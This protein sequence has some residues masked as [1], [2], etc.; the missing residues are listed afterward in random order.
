[1]AFGVFR[2][3]SFATGILGGIGEGSGETIRLSV[4]QERIA[5]GRQRSVDHCRDVYM[6]THYPDSPL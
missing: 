4:L 2:Y 6:I 5:P 1:M 3:S